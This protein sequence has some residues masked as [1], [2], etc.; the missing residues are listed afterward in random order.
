MNSK[1]KKAKA[2]SRCDTNITGNG[3]DGCIETSSRNNER[4][5]LDTCTHYRALRYQ[6]NKIHTQLLS[7]RRAG[8]AIYAIT[9]SIITSLCAKQSMDSVCPCLGLTLK[10]VAAYCFEGLAR[11]P[12]ICLA[13][14][15]VSMQYYVND[16]V[17]DVV[18]PAPI[19]MYNATLA[20]LWH[21]VISAALT[22]CQ[23]C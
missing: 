7:A 9:E 4:H 17:G 3:F 11:L 12:K 19:G 18:Y 2:A 20:F 1:E 21:S 10:F 13:Y 14:V 16:K 8:P 15:Q 5:A 6:Y 22:N 23:F